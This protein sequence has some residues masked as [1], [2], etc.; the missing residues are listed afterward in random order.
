MAVGYKLRRPE[1]PTGFTWLPAL[2]GIIYAQTE[3]IASTYLLYMHEGVTSW[4]AIVVHAAAAAAYL[5]TVERLR[6]L[7]DFIQYPEYYLRR[8]L[9]LQLSALQLQI[10]VELRNSQR[11]IWLESAAK[12]QRSGRKK[13]VK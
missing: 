11:E 12:C 5:L 7:H 9:T 8:H 2:A 3:Y 4:Q 1:C 6:I 13:A 10:G